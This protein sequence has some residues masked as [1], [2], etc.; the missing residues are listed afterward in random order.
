MESEL[1][2]YISLLQT[3]NKIRFILYKIYNKTEPVP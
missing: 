2:C 3:N 1:N